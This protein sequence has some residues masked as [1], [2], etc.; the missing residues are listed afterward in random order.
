MKKVINY[1]LLISLLFLFTFF[2][3]EILLRTYLTFKHLGNPHINY[4]G[5]TW[6]SYD[7]G[8]FTINEFDENLVSNL[9]KVNYQKLNFP[10]WSPDA[11][12]T[13]NRFGFREND[14]NIKKYINNKKILVTGDSFTFGSQVSNNET[15][16]SYLENFLKIKVFNGGHPGYGTGQSIRR[17]SILS[18][19]EKFDYFIWSVIFNDF[20]RDKNFK[21]ILEIDGKLKFNKFKKNYSS[22]K[23]IRNKTFYLT[24][25]EF[26][27]TVYLIDREILEKVKEKFLKSK[28]NQ[29]SFSPI[30]KGSLD[31]SV[32]EQVQFLLKEFLKIEI[33][34]KYILLQHTDFSKNTGQKLISARKKMYD[35]KYKTIL[36]K[37][38]KEYGIKIIDTQL[39]FENMSE[40]QKRLM[41]LDHHTPIG[42]E[43]IAKF[44]IK[45]I[46]F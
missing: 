27:F 21:F 40:K 37:Y 31:Y 33:D 18:K 2:L 34:N 39:V 5:K 23:L 38:A 41:W 4:W 24:L 36:F 7:R 43:F 13:I 44:I 20:N 46:D 32:E 16:P 15:W 26:F 12:I 3:L 30:L 14:N 1:F 22:N 45:N 35:D 8:K 17:A 9:K 25:K 28:K 11:N 19:N 42:N 29:K 10:R 6:Y